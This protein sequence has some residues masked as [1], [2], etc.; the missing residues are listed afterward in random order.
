MD[1][2]HTYPGILTGVDLCRPERIKKAILRFGDRF[3]LRVFTSGE[4]E[5]C[6]S[7]PNP[8]QCYAARFAAKEAAMK[9]LGA[10]VFD[11]GF[12]SVE[13]VN[14]ESGKPFLNFLGRAKQ[15][16]ADLGIYRADISLSHEKDL[17][18]AMAVALTDGSSS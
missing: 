5:R 6:S 8:Y 12:S 9:I 14:D 7:R 11:I 15:R 13:V 4:I 16:A 1:T 18:I 10:G 17:A 2:N 3:L